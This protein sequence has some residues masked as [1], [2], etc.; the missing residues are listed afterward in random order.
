M[1]GLESN[2]PNVLAVFNALGHACNFWSRGTCGPSEAFVDNRK[3]T[4]LVAIFYCA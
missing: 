4:A 3:C 2:L 1:C